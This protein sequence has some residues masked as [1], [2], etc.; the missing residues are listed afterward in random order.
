MCFSYA[1]GA[2]FFQIQLYPAVRRAHDEGD[3]CLR[4]DELEELVARFQKTRFADTFRFLAS[5]CL[6]G[7]CFFM[8][9]HNRMERMLK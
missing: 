9:F 4:L 5:G 2:S 7:Q 1:G 6:G 3:Q 8:L